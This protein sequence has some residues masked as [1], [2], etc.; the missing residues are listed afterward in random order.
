MTTDF[1]PPPLPDAVNYGRVAATNALSDV[2]AMGGTP[3]AAICVAGF[4]AARMG[5]SVI[6]ETM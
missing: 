5:P 6:K 1:F 2:Y 3:R 4:P